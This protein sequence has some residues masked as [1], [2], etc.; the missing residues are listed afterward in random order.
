VFHLDA[1]RMHG[2][3]E[4]DDLGFGEMCGGEAVVVVEWADRVRAAL[5]SAALFIE[6]QPI[7]ARRDE[8]RLTF[9]HG[10]DGDWDRLAAIA[11]CL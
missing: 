3:A 6:L 2:E 5:P 4:L 10:V 7:P 8:R 9:R 1:Y 11:P